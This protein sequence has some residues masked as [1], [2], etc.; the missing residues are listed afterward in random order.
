MNDTMPR[1][2]VRRAFLVATALLGIA[3]A[4]FARASAAA[5]GDLVSAQFVPSAVPALLGPVNELGRNGWHC[6][7]EQAAKA[8][9]ASDAELPGP[10]P[11]TEPESEPEAR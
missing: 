4:G 2:V 6:V 7:P 3:G 9:R 8:R 11:E 10:G 1:M 5:L